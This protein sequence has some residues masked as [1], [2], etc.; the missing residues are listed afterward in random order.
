VTSFVVGDTTVVRVVDLEL[1]LPS[2]RPV[3]AWCVP[4]FAPPGGGVLLAFSAWAFEV[5]GAVVVVDPWLANDGPREGPDAAETADRLLGALAD[6]GFD[7][8]R[9][10]VVVNTHLDGVGWNTR[11]A[12]GGEGGW[13]PSFPNAR[14]LWSAT[15]LAIHRDDERLRPLRDA[16]MVDAVEPPVE[17]VAGLTLEDGPGHEAGHLVAR[18]RS[19]GDEAVLAGHLF[20]S[21]LQVADPT[22]DLDED[23]VVAAATRTTLL[24]GLAERGGLLLAD[25]LGGPGGGRVRPDGPGSWR[26]E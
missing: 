18:L 1:A 23:P 13:V 24:T 11:P 6:A 8:D 20:I 3:P 14:Y 21:P 2:D 22:I 16:G 17:P 9:V 25:L 5:D 7:P 10:D 15:Q 12:G 19:A 4:A 26:L